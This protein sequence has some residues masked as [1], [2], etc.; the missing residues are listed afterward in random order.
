MTKIIESISE[1]TSTNVT[2]LT[3]V[4]D[5]GE[6]KVQVDLLNYD[7]EDYGRTAFVW[8]LFVRPEHRRKG[9]AKEL[10]QYALKR[11]KEHGFNTATLEWELE[12]TPRHIAWWY[13]SLGFDEKEFSDSY[14]LMVKQL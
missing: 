1:W 4:T 8:D 10:M 2:R 9:I 13:G 3:I 12:D 7:N 11:A 6:G 5:G 14:A